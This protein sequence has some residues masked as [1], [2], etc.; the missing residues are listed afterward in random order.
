MRLPGRLLDDGEVTLFRERGG[1]WA[2]VGRNRIG[3]GGI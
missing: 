3:V 2:V 1:G